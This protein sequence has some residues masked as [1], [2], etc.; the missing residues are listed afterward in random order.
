[1]AWLELHGKTFRIRFRHGPRKM[2]CLLKTEDEAE[3]LEEDPTQ[4]AVLGEGRRAEHAAQERVRV[5]I[6]EGRGRNGGA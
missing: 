1:M 4:A 6:P 5:E 2:V 3:A